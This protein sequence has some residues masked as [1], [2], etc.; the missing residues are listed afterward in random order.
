MLL[1]IIFLAVSLGAFAVVLYDLLVLKHGQTAQATVQHVEHAIATGLR[2]FLTVAFKGKKDEALDISCDYILQLAYTDATENE[3]EISVSVPAL[4]KIKNGER[5]R[6][7][8]E[9]DTLTIRYW[10]RNPSSVQ[11]EDPEIIKRQRFIPKLVLWGISV[12]LSASILTV[13]IIN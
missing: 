10:S 5:F 12:I 9:G 3:H 6:Y 7:F 1:C 2:S 4:M 8:R 13:L 11:I